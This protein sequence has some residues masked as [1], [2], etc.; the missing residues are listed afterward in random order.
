MGINVFLAGVMQG[1][2]VELAIH[3]QGW[4]EPIKA[5]LTAHLPTAD[6]YC[7]YTQH[8]QSVGYELPQVR[9]TLEDGNRRAGECDLLIAYLPT[10]SM[11]TA[12]E[13]Y[14][15]SR[16]GA[17]V[18]TVTPLT[19]NWVVRVYSDAVCPDLQALH[20]LAESGEL[21]EIVRRKR[22]EP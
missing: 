11:G 21:A 9:Q 7:H 6:V 17:A 19:A 13:M 4:R 12:I 22:G 15:A 5:I 18:V 8:P 10:A 16:N 14:E 1:S 2:K 3:D 20:D